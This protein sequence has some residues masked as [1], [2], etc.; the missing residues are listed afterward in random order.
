MSPTVKKEDQKKVK[1]S[2]ISVERKRDVERIKKEYW[3]AITQEQT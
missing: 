2:P 1:G 3:Q